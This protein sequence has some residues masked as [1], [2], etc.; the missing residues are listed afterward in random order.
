M[1]DNVIDLRPMMGAKVQAERLGTN[2]TMAMIRRIRK[3]QREGRSGHVV[4]GELME[5]RLEKDKPKP[6]GAAA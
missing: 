3:E 2:L 5:R 1:T 4:A 6:P